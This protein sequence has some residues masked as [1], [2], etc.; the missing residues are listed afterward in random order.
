MLVYKDI[1]LKHTSQF[2]I[3]YA[4]T[5]AMGI[6]NNGVY[7]DLFETGRA[8]LM[9][10]Y[11]LPYLEFEKQGFYLPVVE[12]QI[13]FVSPAYYDDLLDITATFKPEMKPTIKFEYN[14]SRT[15]STIAKGY[16]IHSFLKKENMKPVKPPAI[17]IEAINSINL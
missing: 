12:T 15:N 16:T 8:E 9:R 11:G 6:A 7:L 17:F 4:D 10:H 13:K 5:D 2:R 14:I 3:R 1:L